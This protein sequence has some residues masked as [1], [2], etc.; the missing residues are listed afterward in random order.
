M[1]ADDGTWNEYS[2]PFGGLD[3]DKNHYRQPLLLND[4]QILV[5]TD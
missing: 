5:T 1:E 4:G 2:L 3:N